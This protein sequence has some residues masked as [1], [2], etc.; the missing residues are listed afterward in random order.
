MRTLVKIDDWN[1]KEHFLFF[2]QFDE[3]FFG[4]T[5]SADCTKAYQRAKENNVSFFLYY[6]YRALKAAN[7]IE[8]FRYRIIDKQ[9]YMFDKV[10][11]SPTISRSNGTFGFAYMD[12]EQ[13]EDVFY[14]KAIQE[15]EKVRNSTSLLPA[16]S[17]EN[18]IHCSAIPW[19][20]F[21]SLSHARSF[22]FPDS[23]PKISFG[24]LT[25]QKS[26]QTM[27]VSIHVH[28]GLMDGYHVGLFVNRFQEFLNE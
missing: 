26:I 22:A 7:E 19:L 8:N 3:P 13:D 16:V 9:V 23:S 25:E 4:I 28:H 6:L 27:P 18:V 24:K 5:V 11:A 21:T 17:G 14:Y 15:T 20:N 12:Y 2:S 1:R 10:N